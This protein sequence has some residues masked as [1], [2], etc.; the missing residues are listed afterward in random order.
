MST[1]I[2]LYRK[3]DIRGQVES[4]KQSTKANF[5]DLR[6]KINKKEKEIC[7]YYDNTELENSK[8]YDALQ[9][10]I[11]A[12]VCGIRSNIDFLKSNQNNS[13]LELLEF[14]SE[15]ASAISEQLE[16]ESQKVDANSLKM[17]T[18]SA[19]L[20]KKF[21]EEVNSAIEIVSLLKPISME[22]KNA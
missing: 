12:K 19:S 4:V 9:K 18:I 7:A 16:S 20:Q 10:V 13:G 5:D 8:D 3:S 2:L 14:Y 6:T 15:N 21:K 22:G 1:S 11:T 17:P